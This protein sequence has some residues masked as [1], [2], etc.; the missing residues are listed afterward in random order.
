MQI[1]FELYKTGYGSTIQVF[2]YP[3]IILKEISWYNRKTNGS[4]VKFSAWRWNRS[5]G[6]L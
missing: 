6:E 3:G 4:E 5:I 2:K 1:M